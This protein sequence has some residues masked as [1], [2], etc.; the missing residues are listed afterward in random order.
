MTKQTKIKINIKLICEAD[1]N[2][3]HYLLNH[4][5]IVYLM[6]SDLECSAEVFIYLFGTSYD[7]FQSLANICIYYVQKR[8]A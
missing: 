6:A 2:W 4:F 5:V 7:F 1:R 8:A 3:S